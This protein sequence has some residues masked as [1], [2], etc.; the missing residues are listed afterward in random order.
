MGTLGWGLGAVVLLET[1]DEVD[2]DDELHATGTQPVFIRNVMPPTGCANAGSVNTSS[3]NAGSAH[4]N[5][6]FRTISKFDRSLVA[7]ISSRAA[8]EI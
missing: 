8:N 7:R 2:Q 1:G 3:T 4:A 5:A 6:G